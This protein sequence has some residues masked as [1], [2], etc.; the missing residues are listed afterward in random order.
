MLK[1][2]LLIYAVDTH[3]LVAEP[4]NRYRTKQLC[5]ADGQAATEPGKT[6]AICRPCPSQNEEKDHA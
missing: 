3:Q 2:A 5:V 1:W 6:Y 4:P